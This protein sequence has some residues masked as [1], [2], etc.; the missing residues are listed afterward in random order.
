[1]RNY[2]FG[3]AHLTNKVE[4]KGQFSRRVLKRRIVGKVRIIEYKISAVFRTVK[5]FFSVLKSKSKLLDWKLLLKLTTLAILVYGIAFWFTVK[6]QADLRAEEL[7]N[8][9]NQTQQELDKVKQDQKKTTDDFNKQQE[10][11]RKQ[12]DD[13]KKLIMEKKQRKVYLA[14][15]YLP[16][17]TTSGHCNYSLRT[18]TLFSQAD[19]D[20]VR[21]EIARVY[22]PAGA[23]AVRIATATFTS[24]SGLRSNA[25]SST[26]DWGIGQVNRTAHPQYSVEWLMDY[27]NNIQ[28]TWSI[29][30][31]GTCWTAWTDFK[32]GNYLFYL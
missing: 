17:Q 30:K 25:C 2:N 32:N 29:S 31:Q 16:K 14:T 3:Q 24:E 8:K 13:T 23:N 7:Q 11:L 26:N 15:A 18:A 10:E 4:L 28:A 5:E 12:L 6:H 1:M 22:A 27:R 9:L 19:K 21:A 20:A